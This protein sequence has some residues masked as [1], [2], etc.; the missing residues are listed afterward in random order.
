MCFVDI[1][2]IFSL[3]DFPLKLASRTE[4]MRE[5]FSAWKKGRKIEKE[6]TRGC[7][8]LFSIEGGF[9]CILLESL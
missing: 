8:Q 1:P 2:A 4:L 7:Y 9:V 5:S 6:A 3:S